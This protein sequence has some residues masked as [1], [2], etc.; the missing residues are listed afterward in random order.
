MQLS[1][2]PSRC[3]NLW[4]AKGSHRRTRGEL[5]DCQVHLSFGLTLLI[6]TYVSLPPQGL[7]GQD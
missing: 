4:L 6:S 5:A 7:V 1:G 3:G 2:F